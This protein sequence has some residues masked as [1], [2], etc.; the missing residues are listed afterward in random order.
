MEV[1][2]GCGYYAYLGT[3]QDLHDAPCD[4]IQLDLSA[5]D[6]AF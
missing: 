6:S 4:Y 2:V 3:H 1:S 5:A